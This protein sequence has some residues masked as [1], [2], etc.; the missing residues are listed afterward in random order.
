MAFSTPPEIVF[1]CGSVHRT[2]SAL[3]KLG[4]QR[5]LLVTDLTLTTAGLNKGVERSLIDCGIAVDRFDEGSAKPTLERVVACLTAARQGNYDS[6]VALGGGSS[7]DV[8]KWELTMSLR[9]Q[10]C[11]MSNRSFSPAAAKHMGLAYKMRSMTS[12]SNVP[13]CFTVCASFSEK[14]WDFSTGGSTDSISGVSGTRRS[15]VPGH[16][17]QALCSISR[18]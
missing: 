2:G 8:T 13:R 3:R 14:I 4:A 11:S 16:E 1:G 10:G 6:L 7:I 15:S 9:L 12:L 18:G 17:H 5:A